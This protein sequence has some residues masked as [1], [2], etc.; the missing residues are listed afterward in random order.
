VSFYLLE[1]LCC[2][3]VKV[4]TLNETNSDGFF[5]DFFESRMSF[6]ISLHFWFASFGLRMNSEALFDDLDT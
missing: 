3:F 6:L 1:F 5:I 4:F 2:F